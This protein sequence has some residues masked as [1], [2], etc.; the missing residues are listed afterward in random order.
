M[1]GFDYLGSRAT[2]DRLITKFGM[3]ASLR[4]NGTDRDCYVV[5]VDY[6]P[7]DKA[8][9]MTN[10]TD[11]K[12]VMSAGLGDVPTTPPV[13]EKDQL[14][15]YFQPP[16]DPPVVKEILPFTCPVQ[17]ISPAGVVVAYEFTVRR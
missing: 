10:P 13:N 12:V 17:P 3:K 1:S 11:R 8:T 5:I 7:S 14:V 16:D 9:E 4:R 6:M 2:A 15:T